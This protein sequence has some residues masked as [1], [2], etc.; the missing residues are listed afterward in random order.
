MDWLLTHLANSLQVSLLRTKSWQFGAFR[1]SKT[2]LR[3]V[4]EMSITSTNSSQCLYSDDWAGV[5]MAPLSQPLEA[6]MARITL[7]RWLNAQV[8]ISQ[9]L[10]Q[11][12]WSQ[13]LFQGSTL[14][15]TRL[16]IRLREATFLA[17]AL[18]RWLPL[19]RRLQ[20]GSLVWLSHLQLSWMPSLWVS[21]IS[22][23]VSMV[24]YC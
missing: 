8:G 17:T 12:T 4:N 21:L 7:H 14:R 15:S 2:S 11:V 9:Q 18:S 23:G 3:K 10:S 19:S 1:I 13:S 5:Q 24:T 16:R 20:F 22:A 6:K